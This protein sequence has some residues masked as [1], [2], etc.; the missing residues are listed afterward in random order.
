MSRRIVICGAGFL[1]SNIARTLARTDGGMNHLP[2]RIQISSRNPE[3]LHSSL[4]ATIPSSILLPPVSLDITRSDTLKKA[5]KDADV[6]VSLVGIMHGSPEDF[7]RIQWKGAENVARAAKEVG[8]KLIHVSAIGANDS[9]HIA[10][11]R[12][13]GLAEK[14]VFELCPKATV[15]RPS[16]VFGPEDDFFNRFS[17]LSKYLP[18]LPVF[19]GGTAK[20][21]PVYVGDIA[22]LVEIISRNDQEVNDAVAGKIIEAGG[23]EV[24]TYREVMELVLKYNHRRRPIVSLPFAVG[25]LQG[26][27]MQRLPLNLF[28]VTQDQVEQL[29]EDSIVNPLPPASENHASFRE[30]VEKHSGPL[31]SVHDVLPTYLK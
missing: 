31:S 20:Y 26:A 17:T 10:Y 21:Q 27:V 15:I 2:T 5:F 18:F 25:M 22:R 24:F 23:P 29:K 3:K 28:T 9:S 7:E 4:K 30:I 19:G 11:V 6:I 8:A 16:L 12:T 13:K 1:G 14:A